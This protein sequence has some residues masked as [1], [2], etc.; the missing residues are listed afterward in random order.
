MSKRTREEVHDTNM[1]HLEGDEEDEQYM[2]R[3]KEDERIMKAN[4]GTD[5]KNIKTADYNVP[6][7]HKE[8]NL[9]ACK[10]CRLV[11]SYK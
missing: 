6:D 8:K 7:D 5:L 9:R 3:K 11:K 2:I 10:K 1:D 4:Y